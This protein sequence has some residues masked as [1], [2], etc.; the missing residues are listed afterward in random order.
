MK[1]NQSIGLAAV[2]FATTVATS[3]AAS[4]EIIEDDVFAELDWSLIELRDDTLDD[5]AGF[6]GVQQ[7]TGGNPTE[8]RF[9]A[10]SW[11]HDGTDSVS[12]VG[13]HL[14]ATAEYQPTAQGEVGTVEWSFDVRTNATTYQTESLLLFV[15]VLLQNDAYYAASGGGEATDL[16][17]SFASGELV[18][19]DFTRYAGDPLAPAIP[20]FTNLGAPLTFGFATS[21]G[22]HALAGSYSTEGGLDNFRVA[23]REPGSGGNA[24]SGGSGGGSS[25]NGGASQGSGTLPSGQP[26]TVVPR[27]D[28]GCGCRLARADGARYRPGVWGLLAAG[29]LLGAGRRRRPERSP[30]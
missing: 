21:V 27:E 29:A 9:V 4:N 28:A 11:T 18:A 13:G 12:V 3:A 30:I 26:G 19:E 25:A 23:V 17:T 14:R 16:W 20:D 2:V 22:P 24:G 6:I 15:P 7:S 10:N 8:H 1:P 5:S